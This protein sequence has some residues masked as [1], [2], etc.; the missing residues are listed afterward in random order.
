[1]HSELPREGLGVVVLA[2]AVRAFGVEAELHQEPRVPDDPGER[3]GL[4]KL[5]TLGDDEEGGEDVLDVA[6]SGPLPAIFL[7]KTNACF[8]FRISFG[9]SNWEG[10]DEFRSSLNE[11]VNGLDEFRS[12]LNEW[13]NCLDEFRTFLDELG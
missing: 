7:T 13:V 12:S 9:R 2:L 11:W 10:L 5:V 8:V 1:M 4:R 6:E 3:R